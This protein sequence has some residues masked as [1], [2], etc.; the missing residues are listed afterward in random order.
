MLKAQDGSFYIFAMPGRS[1]GTGSQKLTL[2]EGL[3]GASAE[4]LFENRTVSIANSVIQDTFAKEF[5]YHVYKI[6][7]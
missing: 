1:G 6:T 3:H 4:V 7:P 2:P 5:S